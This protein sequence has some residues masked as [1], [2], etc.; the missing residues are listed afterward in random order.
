MPVWDGG[1]STGRLQIGQDHLRNGPDEP[2]EMAVSPG[3]N[4]GQNN[5]W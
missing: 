5:F 4:G 3:E 2:G 1:K